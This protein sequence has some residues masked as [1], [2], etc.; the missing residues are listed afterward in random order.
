MYSNEKRWIVLLIAVVLIAVILIVALVNANGK[1][2]ENLGNPNNGETSQ[3]VQDE[4]K[5]TAELSDG[6]KINTSEDFNKTKTYNGLEISNIQYTEKN[7]MTVLLADVKNTSNTAH[8]LE[9]VKIIVEGKNGEDM[10]V[11]NSIIG[12]VGP[13]E[14]IE[15]N[16][17]M[18]GNIVNA[19]DFR[20]EKSE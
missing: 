2:D 9:L 10:A 5:Y 19:R 18:T 3:N 1:E 17:S 8:S 15:L 4:E 12:D 13:G 16:A 20:I 14:T 11:M 6:T 7:G